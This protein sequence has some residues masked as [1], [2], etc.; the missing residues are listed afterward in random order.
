MEVAV[1]SPHF[2]RSGVLCPK[3][4]ALMGGGAGR[5]NGIQRRFGGWD[6][7]WCSILCKVEGWVLEE[8]QVALV[9]SQGQETAIK[10]AVSLQRINFSC[11]CI[12]SPQTCVRTGCDIWA[13][14]LL[15]DTVSDMVAQSRRI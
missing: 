13:L 8:S 10:L 3:F 1:G 9:V 6:V 2:A 14:I 4:L 12:G 7:E 15:A 11:L 5:D